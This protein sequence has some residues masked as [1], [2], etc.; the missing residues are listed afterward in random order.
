MFN[1][2]R[3]IP[4]ATTLDPMKE[5]DWI[6]SK[7]IRERPL[8]N[9]KS[10][11]HWYKKFIQET[12]AGY[13]ELKSDPR[14][15]ISRYW[16]ADALI[17]F[18]SWLNKQKKSIKSQ[19]RYL[20]Y[21]NVRTAMDWAYELGI[22]GHI[23]YHA[24]M[25]KGLP[26]TDSR[27]PYSESEQEIID[28]ALG[29]WIE[30][31]TNVL[32]PY[33][34]TGAG[35]PRKSLNKT[36]LLINGNRLTNQQAEQEFGVEAAAIARRKKSGWTDRQAVE[37]DAPPPGKSTPTSIEVEGR[38]WPSITKAA[39]HYQLCRRSIS[40]RLA[41]GATPEQA[42]GLEPMFSKKGSFD[43]A[44]YDFEEYYNCDALQMLRDA[45]VHRG[46]YSIEFLMNFFIKLGV[47][48]FMADLRLVLPLAAELCRLTGLNAESV[49]SLTLDSYQAKHPLT[50]QPFIRYTKV[51]SGSVGRTED[52]DLHVSLLEDAEC[53]IEN[54]IQKKVAQII[55]LATA[56]TE[57]VRH[58]A[59]GET[60]NR[61]FIFE[62]DEW[63]QSPGG[64][65]SGVSHLI[66]GHPTKDER[67]SNAA[68]SGASKWTR[69]FCKESGLYD[70]LGSDF[71]FNI[72]RFRATLINNMVKD[73]FD[74]F[75]IQAAVGHQ[76]VATTAS[77]LSERELTPEFT[78][79]VRPALEEISKQKFAEEKEDQKPKYNTGYTDT[80]CGTGC[81]DAYNP[82][83]KV[84]ELTNH[85]EG[86]PCKY[87]NMCLLCE[88]ASITENGLPKIIAYKWKIEEVLSEPKENM[89]GRIKLYQEIKA[90]IDELLTPNHTYPEDVLK[91]A[92]YIASELDDEALDHLVFQGF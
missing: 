48:P 63:F 89:T 53:F 92:E 57:R 4:K 22:T 80:L 64:A 16:E 44:L 70:L 58:K 46:T 91:E 51:R 60:A 32:K 78:K 28:V 6:F 12:N 86:S 81:K 34:K 15:F 84:R 85:V 20:I 29:R 59:V 88:Q 41:D 24:P 47:W 43:S 82:S 49:A 40:R 87:W 83:Q 3:L 52:R 23:V 54:G 25:F 1:V 30:H 35:I 72:S 5:V 18:T 9:F 73:G 21:K 33:E 71:K 50:N 55:E 38:V 37:L 13:E 39:K 14:F 66:W 62:H 36:E 90:V 31:A 7:L 69:S 42:V 61:L 19:T 74:I 76:S 17:R 11:Q 8:N 67:Q 65:Q 10:A 77:Y 75:S 26:E 27:A 2:V 68:L 79:T 45:K 56:L